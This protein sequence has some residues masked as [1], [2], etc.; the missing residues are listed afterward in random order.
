[1]SHLKR[2]TNMKKH[3]PTHTPR[4][5]VSQSQSIRIAAFHHGSGRTLI[6]DSTTLLHWKTR[7]TV[8]LGRFVRCQGLRGVFVGAISRQNSMK[9]K[10][11]VSVRVVWMVSRCFQENQMLEYVSRCKKKTTRL[12]IRP[13]SKRRFKKLRLGSCK[14]SCRLRKELVHR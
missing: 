8:S 14:P 3:T 11:L 9:R 13:A 4:P 2:K 10:V 1:M 7:Q 6:R 5:L 12:A